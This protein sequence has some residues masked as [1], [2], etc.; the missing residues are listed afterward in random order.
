MPSK[1]VEYGKN[2]LLK[3]ANGATSIDNLTTTGFTQ[4]TEFRDTTSK[5][6]SDWK[7]QVP[8]IKS[9]TAPFTAWVTEA[10]GAANIVTLQGLRNAGTVIVYRFGPTTPGTHYWTG[11]GYIGKL[12]LDAPFDGNVPVEGELVT[13]GEVTYSTN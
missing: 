11:S 10:S 13:T 3:I 2:W 1:T 4:A 5:D 12:D 8:T 9:Q 6:S 7:E